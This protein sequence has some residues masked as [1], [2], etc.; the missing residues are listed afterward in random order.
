LTLAESAVRESKIIDF[1]ESLDVNSK[2]D[3][4]ELIKDIIAIANVCGGALLIGVK[5][6]GKKSGYPHN[7]FLSYDSAKIA[8]KISSYLDIEYTDFEI[9]EIK[10]YDKKVACMICYPSFPPR[11]FRKPGDYSDEN[12][13]LKTAFQKGVLYTR[14]GTRSIP[15]QSSDLS[16]MLNREINNRKKSW[17]GNIKKIVQSPF[18]YDVHVVSKGTAVTFSNTG[19]P[20]RL[21]NNPDAPEF[22]I[23]SP[24]KM[25]PFNTTKTVALINQKLK[26][27]ALINSYDILLLRYQY[28]IDE[29]P[30]YY[31]H[32]VSGS[33]QYSEKFISWVLEKYISDNKFFEKNRAR[34]KKRKE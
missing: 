5:D 7:T 11:I 12:G 9:I 27:K 8:D 34:G 19:T 24:D 4:C 14:R 1:K 3:W 15:A 16:V 31:Y 20:I 29:N 32:P 17:L 25:C 2:G 18:D 10:R 33:S 6:D 23:S 26:G 13:K 22:K 21:T 28:R 30:E